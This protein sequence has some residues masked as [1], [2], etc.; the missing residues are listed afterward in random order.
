MPRCGVCPVGKLCASR[1]AMNGK[2]TTIRR[3]EPSLDGIPNRIY[4]G[5]IIEELRR[6]RNIPFKV[7]GTRVYRKFSDGDSR[8]LQSLLRSLQKDGLIE[9]QGNGSLKNQ[10]LTLA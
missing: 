4:R 10:R 6:T 2:P 5:R 8:W 7:L 1:S 9:I 3:H